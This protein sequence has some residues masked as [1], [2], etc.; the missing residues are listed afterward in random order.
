MMTTTSP[1]DYGIRTCKLLH[2][3][4]RKIASAQV[5]TGVV[6]SWARSLSP[7]SPGHITRLL[8][9]WSHGDTFVA[10]CW[11]GIEHR[12]DADSVLFAMSDEPLMRFAKYYRFEA[13]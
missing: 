12:A 13:L 10:P 8:H 9:D 1:P 6:A 7:E 11:H 2:L 4:K 3:K 5:N